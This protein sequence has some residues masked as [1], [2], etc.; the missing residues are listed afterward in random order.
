MPDGQYLLCVHW[1]LYCSVCPHLVEW[2]S[3]PTFDWTVLALQT[4]FLFLILINV[5]PCYMFILFNSLFKARR[6]Q[7][8]TVELKHLV[9][10]GCQLKAW[11]ILSQVAV[12][13]QLQDLYSSPSVPTVCSLLLGLHVHSHGVFLPRGKMGQA[14]GHFLLDRPAPGLK[15]RHQ[16]LLHCFREL[17]HPQIHLAILVFG[18]IREG[19]VVSKELGE[20]LPSKSFLE[21][22]EERISFQVC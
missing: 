9:R 4:M 3:F 22:K 14:L 1:A 8:K 10:A 13:D 18:E 5:K 21:L 6:T 15:E 7:K 11:N 19:L 16:I 2:T 20:W 12:A 17:F